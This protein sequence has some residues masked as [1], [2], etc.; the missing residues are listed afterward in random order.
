MENN[1]KI[2]VGLGNPEKKY[3]NTYHNL[4]FITIDKVAEKLSVAFNKQKCKAAIAETKI[5][6]EKV[7]LAKPLTYMNLSGESVFEL[8]SFFKADLK[9]LIVIF[10][11]Y[12]LN[13]G[14]VRIREKGSAGTHNGMRSI[15]KCLNSENFARI[16]VGFKPIVESPVP[17]IDYVLSKIGKAESEKLGP[18]TERAA[19]AAADFAGGKTVEY[20][21]QRYNG[22]I[23]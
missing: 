1:M 8:V 10:D 5:G 20:I 9:D 22:N 21:M 11:D 6:G 15:I 16:R 13:M 12:D 3:E 23:D 19:L 7:V 18:A 2:I 17:L 14:Q 4:G